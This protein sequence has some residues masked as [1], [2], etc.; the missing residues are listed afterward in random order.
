[1]SHAY[2]I[3][4]PFALP[5]PVGRRVEIAAK[6]SW[7]II[8]LFGAIACM[9][10]QVFLMNHTASKGYALR[11]SEK[12]LGQL[13]AAVMTYENRAAELQALH[14]VETRIEGMGYVPV[15]RMEFVDVTRGSYAM[16][17]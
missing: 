4:L 13:Q 6:R 15:D 17:R 9:A 10:Y 2:A 3:A 8:F 7:A 14:T 12:Q 11:D 16:A 1:M 5:T